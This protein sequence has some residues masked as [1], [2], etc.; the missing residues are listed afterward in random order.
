[1]IQKR[2]LLQQ[3]KKLNKLYNEVL[4]GGDNDLPKYYS[5]LAVLELGSWVEE[6]M[7]EIVKSY[8]KRKRISEKQNTDYVDDII[9]KN[10]GFHYENNFCLM[11]R[12]TLGVIILERVEKHMNSTLKQGL[13]S[14][15]TKIYPERNDHAHKPIRSALN[16][17]SPSICISLFND[18]YFGLLEKPLNP[19]TF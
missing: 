3:L 5:R 6:C 15:L 16:F 17:T 11:I 14:A 10:H 19:N 13:E 12:R 9:K 8:L 2:S 1:M 18:I 7:D 4:L